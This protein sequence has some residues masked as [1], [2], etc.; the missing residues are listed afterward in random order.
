MREERTRAIATEPDKWVFR[1]NFEASAA[2]A[3]VLGLSFQFNTKC[4]GLD[5][6][7]PMTGFSSLPGAQRIHLGTH[8]HNISKH[9]QIIL[10][11]GTHTHTH[12]LNAEPLERQP[13]TAQTPEK[14]A[15]DSRYAPSSHAI[16]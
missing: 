8:A 10:I 5:S 7:V 15:L 1:S 13:K 9:S 11:D 12:S 2:L 14:N 4:S 6:K 16:D 3:V